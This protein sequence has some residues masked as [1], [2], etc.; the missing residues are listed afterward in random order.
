[1]STLRTNTIQT[2]AGTLLVSPGKHLVQTHYAEG[3]GTY[4]QFHYNTLTRISNYDTSF[5]LKGNNS[6]IDARF[7][8]WST[9]RTNA[10]SHSIYYQVGGTAGT[11]NKLS[12]SDTNFGDS[13]IW[14]SDLGDCWHSSTCSTWRTISNSS[15][16]T[17]YFT[18]YVISSGPGGNRQ[19]ASS[20]AI[21]HPSTRYTWSISEITP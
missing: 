8:I 3:D 2:T 4:I 16:D 11:W 9:A 13:T 18:I 20:D 12:Y 19:L 1:M 7:H 17:I 15:G 5:T 6:T 14:V 21:G 10:E